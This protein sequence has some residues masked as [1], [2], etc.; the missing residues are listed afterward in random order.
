[1][2]DLKFRFFF[3]DLRAQ[4][5]FSFDMDDQNPTVRR[6]VQSNVTGKSNF[7]LQKRRSMLMKKK[8]VHNLLVFRMIGYPIVCIGRM[9]QME[10]LFLQETM[11]QKDWL[12]QR[13][14]NHEQL[15]F[16][17]AKG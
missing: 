15:L 6:L 3:R 17:H 14:H 5:I 8:V 11:V 13:V 7:S 9:K 10:E 4:D 2:F 16:I 1:M 12:L